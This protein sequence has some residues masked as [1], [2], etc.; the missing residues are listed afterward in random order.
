MDLSG[1]R[2]LTCLLSAVTD[3]GDCFFSRFTEYVTAQHAKHFILALYSE[4]KD[5]FIIVLD[6]ASYFR[7][8]AV[9]DLAARDGLAFVRL[10]VYHPDLNPVG[11]CWKQLKSALGNC[12][13]SSLSELTTAID[14]ALEQI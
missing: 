3:N 8:S 13:F 11:E 14:A 1:Q 9:M 4:F 12:Y 5:D 2:D 7:A 10:P 6:G